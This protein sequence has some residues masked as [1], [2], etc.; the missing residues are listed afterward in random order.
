MKVRAV[1]EA[2][3]TNIDGNWPICAPLAGCE[4]GSVYLELS[5]DS[6]CALSGIA[7]LGLAQGFRLADACQLVKLANRVNSSA[8]HQIIVCLGTQFQC[9]VDL[10]ERLSM[11]FAQGTIEGTAA[12]PVFAGALAR[13]SQTAAARLAAGMFEA[14]GNL[15][16][17]AKLVIC[18]D[19]QGTHAQTCCR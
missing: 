4:R 18:F 14:R 16:L 2:T 8:I 19:C 7:S 15:E 6:R 13:A 10:V 5:Q 17:V 3:K 12:Q 11:D 9:R 1:S